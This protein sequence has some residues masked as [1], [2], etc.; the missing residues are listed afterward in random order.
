ML[1]EVIPQLVK[2]LTAMD[3]SILQHINVTEVLHREG[4]NLRHLYEI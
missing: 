4:I 3:V 2:K 1:N